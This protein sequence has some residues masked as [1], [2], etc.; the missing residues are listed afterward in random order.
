MK[1][2]S[3]YIVSVAL[4][5]SILSGGC[6]SSAKISKKE[7]QHYVINTNT[8]DS[9]AWYT[10]QPYKQKMDATMN[11]VI[12]QTEGALTKDQPE[13]NLGD[14]VCDCLYRSCKKYLGKDSSLLNGV[15]LNNGGL[16]TSL[17][18]GTI[19]VGN[20][21]ELMPF[22]NELV[23]VEL[24]G[25][26]TQDMM[27]YLAVKGGMPVAGIRM[28]IE[29][30]KAKNV[31]INGVPFDRKNHYYFISSDYLANGGDKMDFF[32]NPVK[33]VYLKKLI[34]DVIIEYCK[35]ETKNGHT[36][37]AQTDG[38]ISIAK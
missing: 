14:F 13:G 7:N 17:P 18:K 19:T 8:I 1:L 25:E 12:G 5:C 31:T 29:N 28:Q 37:S 2:F 16:R 11:E 24:S 27:D 26:K 36:L 15:L 20:I 35:D 21:F 9:G 33:V 3:A 30:A 6:S 4:A 23:F 10:I 22:D 38:R 34:R 32:K